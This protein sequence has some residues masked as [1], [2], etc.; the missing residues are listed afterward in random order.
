M[1]TLHTA[2]AHDVNSTSA[3]RR[4]RM[5]VWCMALMLCFTVANAST[6]V[7]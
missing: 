5:F 2:I 1:Y 3:S 6:A 7:A 4:V